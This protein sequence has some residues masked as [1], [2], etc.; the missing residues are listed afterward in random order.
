MVWRDS[1]VEPYTDTGEISTYTSW[2]ILQ[3]DDECEY[4]FTV[5]AT[6]NPY[7]GRD[8]IDSDLITSKTISGSDIVCVTGTT[9]DCKWAYNP[10][11]AKLTISGTGAMEDY[12]DTASTTVPWGAYR[13]NILK[14]VG[15][16]LFMSN[17]LGN[18]WKGLKNT[19]GA[20]TI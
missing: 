10:D 19:I 7:G 6:D 8:Y 5:I 1:S 20:I 4:Y 9:G 3:Y 15:D 17:D 12:I 13:D 18:T 16:S 11:N 14:L 2:G